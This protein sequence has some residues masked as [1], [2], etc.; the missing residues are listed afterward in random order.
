MRR[1][2]CNQSRFDTYSCR[3]RTVKGSRW[4]LLALLVMGTG[5]AQAA[6]ALE[7]EPFTITWTQGKCV[8]CD[9]GFLQHILFTS[10]QDGWGATYGQNGLAYHTTDGGRT[11]RELRQTFTF[12]GFGGPPFFF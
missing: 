10:R 5:I 6:P 8:D 2:L 9:F 4:L 7:K 12:P 11:W 1:H 3:V